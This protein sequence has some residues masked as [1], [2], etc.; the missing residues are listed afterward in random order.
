[1]SEY[2]PRPKSLGANIKVELDL[3]N[4]ATKADL[5][6]ETGVDTLGFAEKIDLANLKPNVDIS[7]L[8]SKVAKW[9]NGKLETT[10]VDI[11][12]VSNLV[13]NKVVKKT[14]Y[15]KLV[16]RLMLFKLLILVI[17]LEK[18]TKTQK[19]IKLKRK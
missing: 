11:N 19:S 16:I 12:E 15:N 14:E 4:Y 3:S 8:K 5:Q 7:G 10:S 13:K 2:F 1:M 18:L 6:N 17:Q 9:N